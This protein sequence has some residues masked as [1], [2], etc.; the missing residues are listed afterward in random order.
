METLTL[1]L[2]LYKLDLLTRDQLIIELAIEG[3]LAGP[4]EVDTISAYDLNRLK[5]TKVVVIK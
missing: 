3:L 5:E 4:I 2:N 1:L